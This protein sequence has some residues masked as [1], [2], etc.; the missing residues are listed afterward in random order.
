MIKEEGDFKMELIDKYI[1]KLM[2][3]KPGEP[4]WN[5]EAIRQGKKAG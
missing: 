4:L 2:T 3:S 5:I 1:D